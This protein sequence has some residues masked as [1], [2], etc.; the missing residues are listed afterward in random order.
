[1]GIS[2]RATDL[3]PYLGDLRNSTGEGDFDVG[4]L[5]RM[6]NQEQL[7]DFSTVQSLLESIVMDLVSTFAE[8]SQESALNFS[9]IDLHIRDFISV[10]LNHTQSKNGGETA[11]QAE[12]F[13]KQLLQILF[14][15]LLNGMPENKISLLLKDLHRDF[16][17][18]MR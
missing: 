17:A 11:G 6:L 14:S 18:E 10:I 1:M 2:A 16:M 7:A 13:L 8:R 12:G 4:V 9:G 5:T 15:S 3:I